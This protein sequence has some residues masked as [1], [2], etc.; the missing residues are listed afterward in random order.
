MW[1]RF[2]SL[3][4]LSTRSPA[5]HSPAFTVNAS[6]VRLVL[7]GA[8]EF[9]EGRPCG[10]PLTSVSSSSKG[11]GSC[12]SWVL[13]RHQPLITRSEVSGRSLP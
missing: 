9:T 12:H 7:Q 10:T 2:L 13:G 4:S 5:A 8:S 1:P 6:V 11:G 3:C